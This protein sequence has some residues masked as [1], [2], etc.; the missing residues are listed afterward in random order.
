MPLM[1]WVKG[2]KAVFHDVYFGTSPDLTAADLRPPRLAYEMYFYPLGATPGTT[3]YWRID[4]IM[5]DGTVTKG[6]VWGF[7][8][9]PNTAYAP[10]LRNGDKWVDPNTSLAWNPGQGAVNHGLY[11]GT[12]QAAVAARDAGASKG[13]LNVTTFDPGTLAKNTTYYW[14]V[15]ELDGVKYPG[16]VWNFT[17]AGGPGAGVKA[18]AIKKMYIGVGNRDKPAKGNAGTIFVDDI[19]VIKAE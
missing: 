10:N 14:A 17:T 5:A 11:F 16:D 13:A 15:D 4:E 6:D 7:T 18:A 8:A 19:K 1:K 3:Y 9:A 12:D 2:D